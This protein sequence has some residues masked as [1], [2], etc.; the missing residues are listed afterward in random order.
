LKLHLESQRL[1]Q[2][3]V[4]SGARFF[5]VGKGLEG[6]QAA[7]HLKDFIFVDVIQYGRA[8]VGYLSTD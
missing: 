1:Q 7:G 4:V 3:G 8:H 6:L 2:F 5:M